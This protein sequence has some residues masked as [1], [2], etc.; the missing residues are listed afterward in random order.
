MPVTTT[1]AGAATIFRC[2]N[3]GGLTLTVLD[4]GA[5]LIGMRV[6]DRDGHFDEVTLGFADV[7][8]YLDPHP[9]FGSTVGRYANRIAGARYELDGD[10]V[11]LE[12]NEG[13]NHL[14]GGTRGFARQRWEATPFEE[15]AECGVRFAYESPSGEGGYPGT[16]AAEAI[17]SLTD[18]NEMLMSYAATSDAP[19]P[20]NLT[21]HAYWNLGGREHASPVLDHELTVH[22]DRFL[23]VTSEQVPTGEIAAVF[24]TAMDFTE[25]KP[26]GQDLGALPDERVG[27][28]HCFVLRHRAAMAPAARLADPAS[29]RVMD[30]VTSQPGLQVYTGNNL[31]GSGAHGGF[32]RF[33]G[34]CLE[35]QHFPDSPNRPEFPSTILYPGE[36]YAQMTIHRFSVEN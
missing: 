24:G 1:A 12:A 32:H 13:P 7:G 4:H 3:A 20:I 5:T 22:A 33:A 21:N 18:E 19:T 8:Q 27:Y 28:D 25:S 36:R 6:P 31:N 10:V 15:P 14:H 9:Y 16:V 35:T 30:V 29:G 23:P 17:Y 2:V 26:I 34:L 11:R